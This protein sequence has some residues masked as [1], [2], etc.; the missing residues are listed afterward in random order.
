MTVLAAAVEQP[1]AVQVVIPLAL[2]VIMFAL[3]SSLAPADFARV[4]RVPRGVLIGLLNFALVSPLLALGIA[5]LWSLEA[6]LAVGLVLLGAT[7]GGPSAAFLTHL[8]KGE[9]ALSVTLGGLSSLLALI[10]VPLWLAFAIDHFAAGDL[11]GDLGLSS[12][13]VKVFFITVLP[14]SLGM[15]ARRRA[16]EAAPRLERR[17]RRAAIVLFA[18][19]AVVSI[20]AE[21]DTVLESFTEIA[22]ATLTLNLAAMGAAFGVSRLARLDRRAATAVALE[23]G[24]HNAAVAITVGSGIAAVL[25]VPAAVY[26]SLMFATAGAFAYAMAKGNAAAAQASP[27]T[28]GS[29]SLTLSGNAAARFSRN[30]VTP[31]AASA[32]RPRR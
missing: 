1:L 17:T 29:P 5:E 10:T 14:L 30:A 15:V 4:V 21:H 24:V 13:V 8:A 31:S 25:T 16:G 20:A 3:G 27:S 9:T 12:L 22:G 11:T 26:A 6:G 19:M 32:D 23:L 28:S 2:A 18:L 7:P